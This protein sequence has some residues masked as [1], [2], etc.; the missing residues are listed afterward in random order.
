MD[1]SGFALLEVLPL[2]VLVTNRSGRITYSNPASQK[3]FGVSASTLIGTVWWLAVDARDRAAVTGW[4]QTCGGD[5]PPGIFEVRLATG[6]G[7]GTWTR[8]SIAGLGP[9]A[10]CGSHIHTIEDISRAREAERSRIATL[11]ALSTERER[12]RVT[13]DCIGDAVISTDARGQVTYLNTVAED[14][15]GWSR[16]SACGQ[17]LGRVFKVI[18]SRTG[19][20]IRDPAEMAIESLGIVQMPA[21]SVLLRP[22]GS[23]LAIE[24]SAAPIFDQVGRLTGAVV[25]FRDR[26]L[27]RENTA[28]MEHLARHDA[29]TGLANRLVFSEHFEQALK[30]ARRH[31]NRVG[32]LFIDLDQFKQ[33][34]D[35]L[36]HEAGD[37]LLRAVA[38]DLTACVRG[39]D[40]VCRHGGDEFVVL[41]SEIGSPDD[42]CN[43]AKK[44]KDSVANPRPLEGCSI[45]LELSIGISIFPDDGADMETLMHLADTAMYH[46]KLDPSR[47]P[48]LHHEGMKPRSMDGESLTQRPGRAAEGAGPATTRIKRGAP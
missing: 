39:T 1:R 14:L 12:A 32:L 46:A 16:S 44:M 36:G 18:D 41:L 25:I 29:L 26:K 35:S 38:R 28:I 9:D 13:L 17:P 31:N 15:C 34:N 24:D 30:L 5:G 11:E 8:H 40:L 33:I 3:L 37:R 48:C 7:N 6:F 10:A 27:S 4:W 45:G 22:D 23:E 43:V 2:G 47:G 21:N 42:A 20:L 19:K